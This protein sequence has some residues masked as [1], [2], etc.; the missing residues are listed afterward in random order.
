MDL[1]NNAKRI[2]VLMTV[3][4]TPSIGPI[5]KKATTKGISHNW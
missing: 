1:E 3:T 2:I 4:T 5:A